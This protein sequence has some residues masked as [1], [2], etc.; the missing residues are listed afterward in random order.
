MNIIRVIL[1]LC[2][3]P[4][5]LWFISQDDVEDILDVSG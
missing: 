3:L 4:F 2:L 1:L 5:V